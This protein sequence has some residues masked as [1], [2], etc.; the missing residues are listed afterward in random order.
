[1]TA[2]GLLGALLLLPLAFPRGDATAD[3]EALLAAGSIEE[4]R[5]RVEAALRDATGQG[6]APL[7]E[8][9]GRCLRLLGRPWEA[10]AAF[11]RALDADPALAAAALGRGEVF[12][13]LADA[14]AARPRPTGAEVR[15]L[16]ADATRWL[17]LAAEGRPAEPR[18]LAGLARAALLA[19]DAAGAARA[20]RRLVE[21]APR[22]AS[23][24][25]LL[26]AALRALD[27]REG[28][29][30]A[31]AEALALS[32]T[33]AA[34]AAAR[35]GDLA[36]AGDRAGAAGAA[37]EF[38]LGV[39]DAE[40]VYQAL[41]Q[42]EAPGRR[43]AALEEGLLAVLERHPDH[44]RALYYLGYGRLSAG[45]RDG[46][47][48]AFR[49]KAEVE[50][51]QPRTLVLVGRLQG[52]RGDLVDAERSFEAAFA[53]GLDPGSEDGARALE[54]WAA[55]GASHG[56]ARRFG[57]AERVYRRLSEIAP[58]AP[59]HRTYLGLSLRR[60]G[61]YDEAEEAFRG[62]VERAPFDGTPSNELGLLHLARG[63][64]DDAVAAF[65]RSA[66]VDPRGTPALE[67]LGNL[68]RAAG[69]PAEALDWFREAHRRACE[70]RDE[71]DRLKFRRLMDVVALE[72]APAGGGR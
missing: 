23:A 17:T 65:R 71:A 51:G 48:E 31:E 35:V 27:D 50:P 42:V 32:P 24:R 20:A 53:A 61:R 49:R 58:D 39:P 3:A 4:A 37:R 45:N 8:I 30:R 67:N 15:A 46:A 21:A 2:G 72:A 43:W 44:P 12:L 40:P 62:A 19:E 28:A 34:A 57:D 6:R 1:V 54:G 47:L 33:L 25:R 68:A 52:A 63:R 41:W 29:A 59:E 11:G 66:E 22:D 18:A 70:F 5:E 7:E 16:A 14:A 9:R 10:E 55:V 38:L 36:A 26:A 56:L 13:D 64:I 60:L 69:R